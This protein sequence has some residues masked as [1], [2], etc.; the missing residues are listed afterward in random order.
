MSKEKLIN[1]LIKQAE[2]VKV[3]IPP[4]NLQELDLNNFC[5]EKGDLFYSDNIFYKKGEKT[6]FMTKIGKES[7]EEH[8][9]PEIKISKELVKWCED[10]KNYIDFRLKE[11]EIKQDE[12][13][14]EIKEYV[15]NLEG[16]KKYGMETNWVHLESKY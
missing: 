3:E 7:D 5:K 6:W 4:E 1:K 8:N 16:G 9:K 12:G 13:L 10:L 14:R 15:D 11:I 2:E